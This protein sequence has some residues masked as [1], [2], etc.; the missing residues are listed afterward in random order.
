MACSAAPSS[1]AELCKSAAECVRAFTKDT[2]YVEGMSLEC[3]ARSRKE[4]ESAY[5]P[6][7]PAPA[8][9]GLKGTALVKVVAVEDGYRE[10]FGVAYLVAEFADGSCLVD[11]VHDWD[12]H[13]ASAETTFGTEW[14]HAP[15]GFRL[16]VESRQILRESL[17]AEELAAGESDVRSD[18]CQHITYGVVEGRFERLAASSSQGS[19]AE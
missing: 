19:C 1:H 14:T 4:I 3:A 2:G 5:S 7:A 18:Y 6:R 12:R 9:S 13:S 11:V 17:D 8:G 15:Q 16:Q 10:A